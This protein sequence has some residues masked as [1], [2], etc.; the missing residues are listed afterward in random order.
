MRKIFLD[1]IDPVRR[2]KLLDERSRLLAFSRKGESLIV[3]PLGE[4]DFIENVQIGNAFQIGY[5]G[6]YRRLLD[7][8]GP[9]QSILHGFLKLKR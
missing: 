5:G 8:S 3:P 1:S 2:E 9:A 6:E 7:P 4:I